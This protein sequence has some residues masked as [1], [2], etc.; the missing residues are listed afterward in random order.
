M[1]TFNYYNFVFLGLARSAVVR[2]IALNSKIN[3]L[4]DFVLS[5]NGIDF[6]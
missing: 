5:E 3:F 4:G 2:I 6:L 1:N